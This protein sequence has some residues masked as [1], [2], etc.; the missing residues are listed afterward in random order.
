MFEVEKYLK[1]KNGGGIIYKQ[2]IL[3]ENLRFFSR[4]FIIPSI[5]T[6]KSIEVVERFFSKFRQC[7]FMNRSKIKR[8]PLFTI[9]LVERFNLCC[10]HDFASNPILATFICESTKR[11]VW[12]EGESFVRFHLTATFQMSQF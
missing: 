6:Y 8:V 7:H 3:S 1:K 12:V 4:V 11:L 5:F 10:C 9:C 2:P